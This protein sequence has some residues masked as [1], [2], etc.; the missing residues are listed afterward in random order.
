MR[1]LGGAGSMGVGVAEVP[2]CVQLPWVGEQKRRS[3]P[4][5]WDGA[6]GQERKRLESPRPLMHCS[7]QLLKQKGKLSYFTK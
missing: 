3:T 5:I 2:S 6:S 4:L 7:E 1:L